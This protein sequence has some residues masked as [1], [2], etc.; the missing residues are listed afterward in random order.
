VHDGGVVLPGEDISGPAHIGRQLVDLGDAADGCLNQ[1][2]IAQI[3]LDKL[4]RGRL[5]EFVPFDV[6]GPNPTPFGL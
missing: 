2:G 5:R 1:M 4:V 6:H 3:A